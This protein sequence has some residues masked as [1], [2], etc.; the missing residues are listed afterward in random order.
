ML[1]CAVMEE[2]ALDDGQTRKKFRDPIITMEARHLQVCDQSESQIL[3][4]C[5]RDVKLSPKAKLAVMMGT[6]VAF[7]ITLTATD[8]Y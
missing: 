5:M 1:D 4:M 6:H 7:S 8:C 2:V 3:S